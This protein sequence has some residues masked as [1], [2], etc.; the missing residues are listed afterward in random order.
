MSRAPSPEADDDRDG[1]GDGDGDG[2]WRFGVDDVGP[3]GIIDDEPEF[4]QLPIEP[5]SPRAENIVFV[6]LG[7]LLAVGLIVVT[8]YPGAF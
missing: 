1:D 8:V 5:E 4:E 6:L 7:V 2:E 3:D